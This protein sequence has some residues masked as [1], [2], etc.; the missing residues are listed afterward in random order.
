MIEKNLLTIM[1][2]ACDL[3]SEALIKA[4][5]KGLEKYEKYDGSG[6]ADICTDGDIAAEDVL[7]KY[8][9]DNLPEFT[10]IGEECGYEGGNL[11]YVVLVDPN[12]CT[13]G[14]GNGD[15][16]FGPIIGLYALGFNI[17]GAEC[18]AVKGIKYLASLKQGFHRIGP[19]E[20][21][22]KGA[23]YIESPSITK[24]INEGIE[25]SVAEMFPEHKEKNLIICRQSNVLNKSRV[26]SGQYDALIHTEWARHDLAAAPIFSNKTGVLFTDHD[27][28]SYEPVDFEEEVRRYNDGSKKVVYSNPVVIAKPK[29]HEKVLE[30]LMPFKKELDAIKNP[31][32]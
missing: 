21:V 31:V 17:A 8:F 25:E 29:I 27:G 28:N 30:A 16:N 12:D 23:I 9:R 13:K 15:D 2:E 3:A 18:N 5:E 24:Y 19:E 14:Y 6:A 26:F 11:D 32:Y 10:F 7:K 1:G 4:R 22:P 20:D